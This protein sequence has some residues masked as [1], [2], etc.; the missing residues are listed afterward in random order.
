MG[1]DNVRGRG[2]GEG[3]VMRFL[4]HRTAIEG[5]GFVPTYR[6]ALILALAAAAGG[7]AL[8]VVLAG[9]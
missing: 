2:G 4:Q 3:D 8:L 1:L 5:T 7:G 9:G 6:A